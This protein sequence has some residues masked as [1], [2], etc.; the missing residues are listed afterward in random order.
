MND[1]VVIVAA[2]RTPLTPVGHYL[3]CSLSRMAKHAFEEM[4]MCGSSHGLSSTDLPCPACSHWP[5]QCLV[6]LDLQAKRGSLRDTDAI[7]LLST[8]FKAV[9]E[10]TGVEGSVSGAVLLSGSVYWSLPV[11]YASASSRAGRY[12]SALMASSA[13]TGAWADIICFVPCLKP[14]FCYPHRPLVILWWAVCWG[15]AAS[16]QTSHAL[17]PFLRAS[18][19][20]CL[21]AQ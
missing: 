9:L 4:S 3:S 18:Q 20:R 19:R 12:N 14:D 2:L 7:D 16:V 6:L 1:D 5:F 21:C 11:L 15:P 17:L 10:K 13:I 8:V